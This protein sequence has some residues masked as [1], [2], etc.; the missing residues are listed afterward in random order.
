MSNTSKTAT[1][2]GATAV[3]QTYTRIRF[4]VQT[5]SVTNPTEWHVM[6]RNATTLAK[7]RQQIRDMRE[8]NERMNWIIY[9][10]PQTTARIVRVVSTCE[11][12]EEVA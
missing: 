8:R 10:G 5:R 6:Y 9:T 11:N 3:Q 2:T 4:E 7:A 1:G 12:L